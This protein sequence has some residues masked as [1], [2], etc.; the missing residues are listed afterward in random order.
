VTSPFVRRRRLATE[1][2]TLREQRGLTAGGLADRIH[3]SRMKISRLEN[4]RSRPD[5]AEIIKI[6][7]ALGVTGEKWNEVVRIACDAAEHGWWDDYGDAMG[8]R[9]RLY[10]DIESGAK[11]IR[12]YSPSAI[13][14]L[15]QTPGTI[16]AMT[17]LVTAE[18]PLNFEPEKMTEARLQRQQI[19]NVVSSEPRLSARVLPVDTLIEGSPLPTVSFFLYTFP[20]PEDPPMAVVETINTD[21]VHTEPHEVER[22]T[23]RYDHLSWAALSPED[24]LTLLREAA[25][26]MTEKTGSS[27]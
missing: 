14:G 18:G 4:A 1:L 12:S 23:R 26:R 27:V 19:V 11:T 10:A 13:P 24:S 7:D 3:Y 6:L 20:D 5:I 22:Y 17:E 8:A 15:L 25:G 2:R 16:A 9:Q 21:I